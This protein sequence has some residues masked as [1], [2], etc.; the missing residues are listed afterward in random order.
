MCTCTT[1][2][3]F[4]RGIWRA[5]MCTLNK[6][7]TSICPLWPTASHTIGAR[8]LSMRNSTCRRNKHHTQRLKFKIFVYWVLTV[9]ELSTK[10]IKPLFQYDKTVRLCVCMLCVCVSWNAVLLYQ[11]LAG[12]LDGRR[13]LHGQTKHPGVEQTLHAHVDVKHTI[14]LLCYL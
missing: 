2:T 7:S 10:N 11:K 12:A 14:V 6:A 13:L 4:C 3:K 8:L 9:C 1:Y 5:L